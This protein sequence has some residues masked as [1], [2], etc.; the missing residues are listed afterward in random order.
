[1]SEPLSMPKSNVLISEIE[2]RTV[3]IFDNIL[4]H[5]SLKATE[6][7]RA[8]GRWFLCLPPY[9][10]DLNPIELVLSK[11]KAHIRCM[12]ARTIERLINAI[13]KICNLFSVE[14]CR[15]YFKRAGNVAT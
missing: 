7:L 4:T 1:M 6:I 14:E 5:K 15:N 2:P 3:V 12:G 9:S 13:G 8:H 11:L 10:Q